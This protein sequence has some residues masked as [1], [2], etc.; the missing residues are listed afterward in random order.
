M[1]EILKSLSAMTPQWL[2][3]A[4]TGAGHD[5]PEVTALDVRPMDDF[6]GAMGEVGIVS[7]EYAGGTGL[8]AEFVAKCPLDNDIARM[9]ASVML[10]YQREAG[11][12]ADLAAPVA[13]ST[14]IRIPRC[15][16]NL[17]DPET[18]SA[19]LLIERVHPAEKGDI[20]DGTSY[21]RMRTLVGDLARLHA[22]HW[23]DATLAG[24]GWL[25]DWMEPTLRVGI[26]FTV[27]SWAN[28][29]EQGPHH[30]PDGIAAMISDV[31][32]PDVESW[33]QRFSQRPW[34]LIHQDY[35]LDNVL[36][37]AGGPVIVDWQTAMLSFPGI[38]LGWL[39]MASHNAET[40]AREPE[41]LDHYRGEL[42]A[43]GGPRW[44]AEDLAEDLAWGAFYW[45][46]VSHVPF[47][48]SLPAGPQDRSHRRFAAMMRG[49]IAAAQRWDVVERMRQHA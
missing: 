33:L 46:S 44:S 17:F 20:L 6:T 5:P 15:F 16:V 1:T 37:A 2:T 18:H 36:F 24:H 21:E 38:D 3:E 43:A 25:I 4:L 27:D 26:P 8:P 45:V 39:L 49:T 23:M 35:E 30:H 12:Y 9:Y 29:R 11:F 14:G 34:T 41:L 48:H 40:L 10:S 22:A 42:A 47:M 31:F 7:V 13:A 32:L 19:T 28:I